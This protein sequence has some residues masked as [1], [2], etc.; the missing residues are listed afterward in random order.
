MKRLLLLPTLLLNAVIT[1]SQP[2]SQMKPVKQ[3][4]L[5][6]I[7]ELHSAVSSENRILNIYLPEGYSPDSAKTYPV[8]YLLDGS[9]DEDFIHIAGLAQFSNFSWVNRLPLSIVVG[10][11]NTDRKRDFTFPAAPGFKFPAGLESYQQYHTVAGSDK[12]ISYIKNELIPFIDKTYKTNRETTLIGQSLGGL[13]ASEIL[14]TQTTMF[15]NYIIVSP[16]LW[17]DNES[18]L[19]KAKKPLQVAPGTKMKIYI[20]VG[21]EGKMMKGDARKLAKLLRKNAPDG[22][23]LYYKY[24]PRENHGTILHPSVADAFRSFYTAE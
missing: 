13:L 7:R 11:A 9:A 8:V 12:F 22:I 20:A 10:I 5:G 21:K 19:A 24:F 3:F 4:V 17:W 1:Q 15:N 23:Q 14:L 18:L 6:E 2:V 16:S